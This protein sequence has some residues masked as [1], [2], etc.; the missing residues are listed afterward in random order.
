M[1]QDKKLLTARIK[2]FF[3]KLRLF[4]RDPYISFLKTLKNWALYKSLEESSNERVCLDTF[5]SNE[6]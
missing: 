1:G 4:N 2:F 6:K 3:L 5:F